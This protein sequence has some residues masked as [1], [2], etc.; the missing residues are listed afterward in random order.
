VHGNIGRHVIG[1]Q[2]IHKAFVFDVWIAN[3]D[4]HGGNI[5]AY[6]RG[7]KY[8]FYLIDQALSLLAAARYRRKPLN[9][10]YWNNIRTY[11]PVIPPGINQDVHRARASLNMHARSIQR[12]P[13]ALI[14]RAVV[15]VPAA[16][17]SPAQKRDTLALL[18]RRRRLL[19]D[20]L[21]RS[22]PPDR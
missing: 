7:A 21:R 20:I 11:R 8:D 6:R 5:I 17:L 1:V 9:S 15:T 2:Q 10:P 4:R 14:R 18:L 12:L 3:I 16:M 22:L 13:T 19:G